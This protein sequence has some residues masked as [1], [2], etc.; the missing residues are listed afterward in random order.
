MTDW[1][2]ILNAQA[3]AILRTLGLME[4]QIAILALLVLAGERVFRRP[5]PKVRYALWLVVLVKCLLPPFFALPESA[6]TKISDFAA[7][8]IFSVMVEEGPLATPGLS[9]TAMV[10]MLWAAVSFAFL[11]IALRRY[12]R[13]RTRLTDA[14]PVAVSEVFSG[15]PPKFAWP[16]IWRVENLPTPAAIGLLRPQ[17]FLTGAAAKSERSALQAILYH[18]LAHVQRGDGWTVLLQTLAQILHPL[19]PFVWLMNLR[20]SRYREEICDDFA[21]Q[22]A[23]VS[24]RRYG[25]ILLQF[26]ETHTASPLTA[27]T[28]TCFFETAN[29]FKQRFQYLLTP[30]ETTMNRLNW[31]HKL[32]VGGLVVLLP[33]VSWQCNNRPDSPVTPEEKLTASANL[34]QYDQPPQIFKQAAVKYP[35]LAL[36][37]GMNGMVWLKLKID[38]NGKVEAVQVEKS[39]PTN[40][41]FEEAA[42]TAAKEFEFIPAKLKQQPVAAWVTIPFHF[43]ANTAEAAGANRY[44]QFNLFDPAAIIVSP[45]DNC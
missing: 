41:G 3:P 29:G 40:L 42:I 11:F 37:A 39:T 32:F 14:Q 21:L 20:L 34:A 23:A 1:I 45:F 8:I 26:L 30:K 31:Q 6:Q 35:Q 7:P 44:W 9:A 15:D 17:I 36:K 10:V 43:K 24:P 38:E 16:P 22:H 12:W 18:E 19:N 33:L 25:E 28:G 5:L 2:Q 13:L 27:Q 4:L